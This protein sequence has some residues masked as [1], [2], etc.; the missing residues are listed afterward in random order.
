MTMFQNYRSDV[1]VIACAITHIR[2]SE[3]LES[4]IIKGHGTALR[5]ITLIQEY[6]NDFFTNTTYSPALPLFAFHTNKKQYLD[7]LHNQT[8]K[9][10]APLDAQ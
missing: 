3:T 7:T 2:F 4:S 8:K 6:T 1:H 10:N 9:R 5:Q